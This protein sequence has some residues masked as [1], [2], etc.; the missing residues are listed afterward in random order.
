MNFSVVGR[1]ALFFLI[2]FL[3]IE[4]ATA[5]P[6]GTR[7]LAP[8]VMKTIPVS[9]NVMEA[10]NTHDVVELTTDNNYPWAKNVRFDR[11]AGLPDQ[12]AVSCL[13][14]QFKPIRMIE[15][16][17]PTKQGTLEKNLVW[18]MIYSVTNKKWDTANKEI[19]QKLREPVTT[20]SL[21]TLDLAIN[22]GSSIS[23][24]NVADGK[25]KIKPEDVPI[26]FIPQFILASTQENA[27]SKAKSGYLDQFIPLA[28]GPI[29]Q[30]ENYGKN[31]EIPFNTTEKTIEPGETV[32]GIAMWTDIDPKLNYFSVFVSGLSTAY[33]WVDPEGV[34]KKG[35]FP[36]TGRKM[37]RKTLKLN[38][39]RPGDAANLSEKDIRYGF[40]IPSVVKISQETQKADQAPVDYEWVYR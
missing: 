4:M 5:Q 13:Q 28:L 27:D 7:D 14:F 37:A 6:I 39:W 33:Q 15:I 26:T 12:P 32:W 35:D 10:F 19:V 36:G 20:E 40:P 22:P 24:E 8:D 30:R 29:M 3:G 18:Y 11:L 2:V 25:H 9:L 17:L 21:P 23:S 16:E 38:F 31:F 1:T 34:Y